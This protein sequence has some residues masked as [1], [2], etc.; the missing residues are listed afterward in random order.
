MQKFFNERNDI[1]CGY[2]D[3]EWAFKNLMFDEANRCHNSNGGMFSEKTRREAASRIKKDYAVLKN[4]GWSKHCPL[5]LHEIEE[6]NNQLV[7][8]DGQGRFEALKQY[9]R[10]VEV[11]GKG[12]KI[13]VIPVNIHHCKTVAESRDAMVK[14]NTH[15]K[16]WSALD[17]LHHLAISRE[18][19]YMVEYNN[20]ISLIDYLGVDSNYIPNLIMFGA[21][22]ASRRDKRLDVPINELLMP[23]RQE[24]ADSFKRF[25]DYVCDR[26]NKN[27]N[28]KVRGVN[29][30]IALES[31]MRTV[32]LLYRNEDYDHDK[33][34][35]VLNRCIRKIANYF[36]KM[37]DEK[38]GRTLALRNDDLR[39]IF[40]DLLKTSKHEAIAKVAAKMWENSPVKRTAA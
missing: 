14:S 1:R 32:A 5:I 4:E 38:L 29:V 22:K 6:L 2:M 39:H 25:Y 35:N 37:T 23:T 10:D 7:I 21:G 11:K 24:F 13:T 31:V 16:N 19:E 8:T 20:L 27:L 28:K 40:I 17:V 33:Y 30:A 26:G 15:Q 3:V 34:L 12:E 18:G 36:K 9:N